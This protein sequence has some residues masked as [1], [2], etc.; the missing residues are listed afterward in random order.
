MG[1]LDILLYMVILVLLIIPLHFP[2]TVRV[3]GSV[4][5]FV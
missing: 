3:T 1:G 4:S 2:C 5:D